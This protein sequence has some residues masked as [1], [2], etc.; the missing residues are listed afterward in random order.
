VL[1]VSNPSLS[2]WQRFFLALKGVIFE[3]FKLHS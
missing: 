3:A 2:L 1:E